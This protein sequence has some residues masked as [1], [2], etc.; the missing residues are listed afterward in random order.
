MDLKHQTWTFVFINLSHASNVVQ[1][2]SNE[3]G[4]PYSAGSGLIGIIMIL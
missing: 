1:T 4:F 3:F 2:S